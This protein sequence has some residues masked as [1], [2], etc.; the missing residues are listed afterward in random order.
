MELEKVVDILAK[1]AKEK[2]ASS[3]RLIPAKD[4]IV[5][6][7]V[8]LKCKYGCPTFAKRFTCPPY[9]STPKETREIIKNYNWALLVEFTGLVNKADQLDVHRLMYD[10]KREAF[11]ERFAQGLCF[12]GWPLQT[13]RELPC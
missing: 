8:R 11:F 2:G 1:S 13:L 6:D 4:I 3:V 9:A 7:Y 12:R 10:L 5:E